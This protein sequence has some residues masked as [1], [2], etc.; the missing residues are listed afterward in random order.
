MVPVS[1]SHDLKMLVPELT[2]SCIECDVLVQENTDAL[3]TQIKGKTDEIAAS[4][5]VEAICR[6]PEIA[7][8]RQAYKVCGKD[9]ARYRLSAEALLRRVV[10]GKGLYRINNV[11][12]LLN[13]VSVS[14]GF[15]IGGYDAGK[16]SGSAVFGIGKKDEPY[17]GIGRGV[18]NI[19]SLPVFR[20]EKGAFGTPTS[21]SVRTSVTKETGRFLMVIIDYGSSEKLEEATTLAV[22]LLRKYAN[23]GN[24]ELKIIQ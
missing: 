15:S 20:D 23:A 18:L 10:Q 21:D 8:S 4:L 2:L 11:V 9:P 13:L 3:W 14:S 24:I 16:I 5:K 19:E 12:D 6:I 17:E 7:A 1:I 22:S